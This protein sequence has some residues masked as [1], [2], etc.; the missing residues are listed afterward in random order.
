MPE[1]N[2]GEFYGVCIKDQQVNTALADGIVLNLSINKHEQSLKTSV[3]FTHLVER[4]LLFA[5][6][7]SICHALNLLSVHIYPK[8]PAQAFSKEYYHD[9]IAELR[10]RKATVNGFLDDSI[11]EIMDGKLS[12]RLFHGGY[13]ILKSSNCGEALSDLIEEEFGI[14]YT[15]E[16]TGQL[17]ITPEQRESLQNVKPKPVSQ[18]FVGL[19]SEQPP[20]DA[21]VSAGQKVSKPESPKKVHKMLEGLPIYLETAKSLYGRDIKGKPVPIKGVTPEDGTVILWGDVFSFETR[22]TKDGRNLIVSFNITD[23]TSSYAVKIFNDKNSLAALDEGLSNGKTVLIRGAISY[24]KYDRDYVIRADAVSVVKKSEPMDEAPVKRVEL[25]MHTNMSSMDGMT[26]AAALVKRAASWGHKAVAITDHGVLQ[27]FPDAMSAAE[28]LGGKIK[29]IYG[30]EAYFINDM[31]PVV[32]GNAQASFDGEFIVFDIETTGLN[33]QTERITEIG[34]VRFVGGEIKEEFNT[35]VNPQMPIPHKITELTGINDDM[36]KNAPLEKEAL[37]HFFAFCGDCKILVAHNAPFDTSFIRAAC[38]RQGMEYDFT[39]IDTVPI[40]RNLY[41]NIKNH[42]LDTV[43]KYLKLPEFNHHR[44]SDDAKM[45]AQIFQILLKDMK[46]EKG[47]SEV[48]RINT[49]LSG[50]D[51]KKTRPFHQIILVR[52]ATGLKNL[53]RLV[54]MAHLDYFYKKPRIPKSE[55][56]KYREGLILG[57]ACEQG[58]LYQAVLQGKPWAEL[59]DIAGFYDYLEIQP[60]GNNLFM[61]RNGTVNGEEKLNEINRTIIKLGEKLGKP[62]VATGDVHFMDSKDEAFRRILMAGQGFSDADQQAPLYF[63]DTNDMLKEFAYLGEKKAYEV[64]VENTNLIADWIADDIRPI[65]KGNYPPSLPGADEE[66]TEICWNTAKRIYGEPV[67]E[68]IA[69][70]LDRELTSIIKHGFAVMYMI[71]QKLVMDSEAHGYLVGSRGS[72]GSSYVANASGIS[73]V[74][75]LPPHYVCPNCKYS[76][77]FLKGEYGSGFDLPPKDCPHCGTALRRDG[78]EIPFETFLGFDGDKEPDIDLNFS[79]EYQS[80]AHKY[81]EELFGAD[82]VFRAGTIASV[83]DKTAYGYV[84][85]YVEERGLVLHRAEEDRLTIG[86]TG[87]KRTTGQHPGGMVVVPRDYDV[88]DFTPVQHPAD[89]ADKGTVTTHFDFNSLHDTILKLDILGHDVPTLY[90]HLEDMTGIKVMSVDVCDPKIIQL[91]T[92]PEPLGVSAQEIDCETGTLSIPEMG[93]PFVRQMLLEAKP[94]TFSDLLQIS[95]LSHGTDV[96]LGNA[97]DLIK[98]GTCTISN[99]IGTRDSIMTYLLHKNMEPKRAFKIMEFTRKGK[100]NKMVPEDWIQDMREHD[101][102][103]WYIESCRKIKYMFPKAHAAAY[104]IAALRLGWYKIYRP[105]E[106]Y[107]AYL[108]VRGGDM[109]AAAAA[110]G[111]SAVKTLLEDIKVKGKEASKKEEDQYTIMQIVYEMLARGY[112]FLPVDLYH[113]DAIVYKIED[114][115]IRLPFGALRGLGEAAA[116]ALA[117]AKNENDPYISIHDVQ[118]RAGVSKGVIE[119]LA[120]AGVLKDLPESSQMSMF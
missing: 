86:C 53:Y 32:K 1:R 18:A 101:V 31:I 40:C 21:N 10:K 114:G 27:A 90:K 105:L 13:D 26:P 120:E 38:L 56:V 81:T 5:A 49:S 3:S 24:D 17:T 73:E 58:E 7:R 82:H 15:V 45:L 77:F 104:V 108:T 113:S 51:N 76:E 2:F 79:G 48:S 110:A 69:Q 97:Q 23:Y 61:V 74:N 6:E 85:K 34:A 29:I 63:R 83:A 75:P 44:A 35:F 14:R 98:N 19:S 119:T 16:F 43:A 65:P 8:F 117:D 111:K 41:P 72:V 102:P 54:S 62:V 52:N 37:E 92:S 67:P 118:T 96:W 4:R 9:L 88:Y 55:L 22:E 103:E 107:A 12:V 25:H 30:V 106:Y 20:F 112:E 95:G 91:C 94:K 28:S 68:I 42:K 71:A 46:E 89:D 64:V 87:V 93:T 66:L 50:G 70:R 36:V 39:G 11:P 33:A 99:V 80:C 116:R 100:F 47:I 84:K 60:N 115:K 109:D 59:L 78:H 57:S